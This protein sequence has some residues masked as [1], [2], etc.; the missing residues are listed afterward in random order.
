MRPDL[1]RLLVDK[2]PKTFLVDTDNVDPKTFKSSLQ[3]VGLDKPLPPP[4]EE[5]KEKKE[6]E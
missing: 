6:K 2:T 5:K 1:I 3:R 4:E